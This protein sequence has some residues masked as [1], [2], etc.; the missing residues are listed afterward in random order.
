LFRV[1][2]RPVSFKR[3]FGAL[4][5]SEAAF[6]EK[7]VELGDGFGFGIFRHEMIVNGSVAT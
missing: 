4:G 6:G 2:L 5:T 7:F 3:A 1:A